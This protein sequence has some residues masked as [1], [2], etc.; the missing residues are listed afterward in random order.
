MKTFHADSSHSET[1][2]TIRHARTRCSLATP[3]AASAFE[4]ML[5]TWER[6]AM[7]DLIVRKFEACA[8]DRGP[9]PSDSDLR[10]FARSAVAEQRLALALGLPVGSAQEAAG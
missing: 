2:M 5:A 6:Q 7:H 10:S 1:K 4:L 9:G 3:Q 8:R